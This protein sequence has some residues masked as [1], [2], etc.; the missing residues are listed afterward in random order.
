[1]SLRAW[2]PVFA[3]MEGVL[4]TELHRLL[5]GED[6]RVYQ[7]A[8]VRATLAEADVSAWVA[9]SAERIVGFVV[10]KVVDADRRI[11]EIAMLAVDPHAQHRGLGTQLT[12]FATSWLRDQ[13]IAVAV[14]ETGGDAGHGPARRVYEQANY[15]L[16]PIA[17]YF[18]AL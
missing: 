2:A 17:R 12:E 6:W 1:M 16:M 4:G 13:G 5:H 14:I 18:K 10:A 15:T 7:A 9:E 3:S 8:S 11:G